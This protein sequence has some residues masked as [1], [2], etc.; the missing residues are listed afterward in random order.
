M[1]GG[2][3]GSVR[4][5]DAA[6]EVTAWA[7]SPRTIRTA[8]LVTSAL[9]LIVQAAAIAI[10]WRW[11]QYDFRAYYIGPKLAAIGE[12]PYSIDALV[13]MS[14]SLG[15]ESNN[16]PFVYPP[17]MLAVFAPFSVLPY[18]VAY[19][20]WLFLQIAA[21]STVFLVATK[22][23]DIDRVWLAAFLAM[24]LNGTVAGCLRSGQLTLMFTALTLLAASSLSRGHAGRA[25]IL[26]TIA[27]LPKIWTAPMIGLVLCRPTFHRLMLVTLGCGVIL[28]VLA[29]DYF[30]VP[31]YS[32][33]FVARAHR[34]S[35]IGA[36]PIGFIDGSLHN[37][38]RTVGH[39][40][41]LNNHLVL[42]CW[43]ISVSIIVFA[44]LSSCIRILR[45][46]L[47]QITH[48]VFLASLG[49]ILINPRVLFYQ[50]CFVVPAIAFLA[51]KIKSR[52]LQ[53]LLVGISL[54]PTLYI[55]RYLF[56]ID[57]P[58]RV[59]SIVAIPWGFSNLIAVFA[60]WLVARRIG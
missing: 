43:V 2:K 54:T 9:L 52:I 26:L 15:L 6:K 1:L 50:W 49:L 32:D 40:L 38:T 12:D 27:A 20:L 47:H 19:G 60:F 55:N 30:W 51:P 56:D 7:S 53:V 41:N 39:A 45:R 17:H 23:F 36:Q 42:A 57:L 16:N 28:S 14:A 37:L 22:R 4:L 21:L 33:R 44:T 35:Q 25:T 29:V 59:E 13:R 3:S 11:Y 24:G 46:D 48:V 58:Q 5:F 34:I 31:D 8:V 10:R 18:P